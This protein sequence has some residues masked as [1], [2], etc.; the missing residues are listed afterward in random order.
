ML[1]QI[2]ERLGSVGLNQ[3]ARQAHHTI[4][5][6]LAARSINPLK[7]LLTQTLIFHIIRIPKIPFFE[8]RASTVL[9]A[10][11]LASQPSG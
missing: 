4:I 5:G 11:K 6:E 2:G 9:I 3:G 7:S 1:E 10:T 8:R